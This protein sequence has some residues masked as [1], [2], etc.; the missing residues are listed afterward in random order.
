VYHLTNQ[1]KKINIIQQRG[2]ILPN[3]NELFSQALVRWAQKHQV[4][5]I[6]YLLSVDATR[7]IDNQI[8]GSQ[9]RIWTS[10]DHPS[11]ESL[12]S[13]FQELETE[14]M[15]YY[16][17]PT[18]FPS[19]LMKACET[20]ENGI[21]LLVFLRFCAEGNNL[22]D[23]GEMASMLISQ[24]LD[25]SEIKN[26]QAPPSWKHIQGGPLMRDAFIY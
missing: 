7:R 6:V 1:P 4:S 3:Q 8:G 5:Q 10:K 25:A 20:Q 16:L 21:P 22:N 2:P 24:F 11:A 14:T 23:S 18:A 13:M 9:N 17:R 26:L 12:R 19:L 15:P